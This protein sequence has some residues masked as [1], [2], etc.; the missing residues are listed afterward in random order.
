MH[1]LRHRFAT[2]AYADLLA[3]QRLLG[4]R[5]AGD[6]AAL[7]ADPGPEAPIRSSDARRGLTIAVRRRP[8]Y[9]GPCPS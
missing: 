8:Q 7:H 1:Q 6:D 5:L 2:R 4:A 9:T 3:V